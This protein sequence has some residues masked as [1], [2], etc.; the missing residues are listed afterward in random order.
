MTEQQ[1][2]TLTTKLVLQEIADSH[3]ETEKPVPVSTSSN[4]SLEFTEA[5][6]GDL[7]L[8]P[9]TLKSERM[10]QQF[11]GPISPEKGLPASIHSSPAKKAK[12]D[13]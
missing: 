11:G 8:I 4:S 1:L 7:A 6:N 5:E 9:S 12:E 2:F 13:N 3:V 10:N